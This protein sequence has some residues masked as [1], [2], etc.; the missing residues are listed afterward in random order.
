MAGSFNGSGDDLVPF[1]GDSGGASRFFT[2]A[3]WDAKVDGVVFRYV[4]KPSKAERHAAG[5]NPHPTVKPVALLSWMVRLVTPPGGVVFD[6]FAGSGTTLVAAVLEGFA[7]VGVELD[8][9]YVPVI[10]ARVDHARRVAGDGMD[11]ATRA[12]RV[13]TAVTAEEDQA[14]LF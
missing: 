4:A 3:D 8:A 9:E 11:V 2:S 7:A 12:V 13:G 10:E 1:Y 6:P 14:S 5:V